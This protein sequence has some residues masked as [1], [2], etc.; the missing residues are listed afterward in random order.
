MR[1]IITAALA[2]VLTLASLPA[3]A[4]QGVIE[5]YRL[6][7][8]WPSGFVQMMPY[9]YDSAAQCKALARALQARVNDPSA[10]QRA[11]R[12]GGDRNYDLSIRPIY[13]CIVFRQNFEEIR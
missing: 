10:M 6:I 8:T 9:L 13:S 12:D 2:A 1:T 7:S 11:A 5:S 4:Q 3:Q